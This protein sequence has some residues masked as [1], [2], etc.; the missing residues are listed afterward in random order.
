MA[1]TSIRTRINCLSVKAQPESGQNLRHMRRVEND[2]NQTGAV[3]YISKHGLSYYFETMLIIHHTLIRAGFSH[4]SKP[5]VQGR[6]PANK[7]EN[8]VLELHPPALRSIHDGLYGISIHPNNNKLLPDLP[9][10]ALERFNVP[11]A[12]N[13]TG[14]NT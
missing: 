10:R 2:Y 12:A 14:E 1:D 11:G 5:A 9:P 3:K 13:R 6:L 4:H 7:P 8:R